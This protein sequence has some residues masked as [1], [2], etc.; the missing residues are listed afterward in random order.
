VNGQTVGLDYVDKNAE[1]ALEYM[2][3]IR[4]QAMKQLEAGV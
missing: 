4:A 3:G 1:L 2:K